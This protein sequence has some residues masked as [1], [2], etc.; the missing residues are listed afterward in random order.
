VRIS[1]WQQFSSNHS[2]RFTVVGQFETVEN[3]NQAANE[4]RHIIKEIT[5]WYY[6]HPELAE[7][8]NSGD[9]PEPTPPE[10]EFSKKYN[11]DWGEYAVPWF[12]QVKVTTYDTTLFIDSD[13]QADAGAFPIN[14]VLVKLRG[15]VYVDGDIFEHELRKGVVV[16]LT[17]IAQDDASSRHIFD[18]IQSYFSPFKGD[19]WASPQQFSKAA[20]WL[21]YGDEYTLP[22]VPDVVQIRIPD[23]VKE[24]INTIREVIKSIIAFMGVPEV[25]SQLVEN[26]AEA[27][28]RLADF[29][30][31]VFVNQDRIRNS[32][33]EIIRY[34]LFLYPYSAR[35]KV[36]RSNN[37][38][39]LHKVR[40]FNIA[41]GFPAMMHY[42]S[43]KGCRDFQYS[44]VE[45]DIEDD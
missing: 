18:E 25:D 28:R 12:W 35:G 40:F 33:D 15:Q 31:Q 1:V 26:F 16:N 7:A 2:A 17:C 42:L 6:S 4:L 13:G 21:L 36:E 11:V 44:F 39:M 37:Q 29:G 20:P 32:I 8:W 22:Y 34:S 3:A 10:V 9:L 24:D 30:Y 23:N 14:E 27:V 45:T 43:S 5:D 38:L 41:H 19:V